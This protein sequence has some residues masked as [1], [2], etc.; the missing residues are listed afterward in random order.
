MDDNGSEIEHARVR[1]TDA[2]KRHLDV[3]ESH[4][5][6]DGRELLL[7]V[8]AREATPT[9]RLATEDRLGD[10]VEEIVGGADLV[11]EE[12]IETVVAVRLCERIGEELQCA[13]AGIAAVTA[14]HH[15]VERARKRAAGVALA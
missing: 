15:A 2:T 10:G 3:G 7:E 4:R 11:P 6:K 1:R 14:A 8:V 13:L 5:T 9:L 12:R